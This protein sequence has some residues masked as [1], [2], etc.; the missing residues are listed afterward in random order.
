VCLHTE[1][2]KRRASGWYAEPIVYR[3]ASEG[4]AEQSGVEG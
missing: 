2:W 3:Q 1:Y 4:V